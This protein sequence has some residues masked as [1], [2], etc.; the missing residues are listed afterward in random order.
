MEVKNNFTAF[1]ANPLPLFIIHRLLPIL[2]RRIISI[3]RFI[4][5]RLLIFIRRCLRRLTVDSKNPPA[6]S[7]SLKKPY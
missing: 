2:L 1:S 7:E 5:R 6:K 3:R 4:L